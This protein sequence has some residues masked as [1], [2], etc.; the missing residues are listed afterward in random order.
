MLGLPVAT[1]L[2]DE[3]AGAEGG[4]AH[5]HARAVLVVARSLNHHVIADVNSDVVDGGGRSAVEDKITGLALGKRILGS[6]V[7][8]ILRP[9]D[10][11]LLDALIDTIES[12]TTAVKANLL[13]VIAVGRILHLDTLRRSVDRTAMKRITVLAHKGKSSLRN[14]ITTVGGNIRNSVRCKNSAHYRKENS[15]ET[16][17]NN[18]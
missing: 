8:L 5:E 9:V 13:T 12:K 4:L 6:V 15:K 10:D 17:I 3:L 1:D 14:G 7:V 2:L 11:A 18:Y 16:H